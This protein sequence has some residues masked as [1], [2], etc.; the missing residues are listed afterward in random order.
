MKEVTKNYFVSPQIVPGDIELLKEQGF[1]VIVC[2][3]PNKE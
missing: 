3:R 1:E 2:N